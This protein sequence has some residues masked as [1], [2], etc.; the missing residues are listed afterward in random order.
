MPFFSFLKDNSD[1]TD[2]TWR[3]RKRFGPFDKASQHLMRGKSELT[4][5]ERE[6]I[7]AYVSSLNS[8]QYCFGSHKS[9]A[10]AF[11]I[12]ESLLTNITSDLESAGLSQKQKPIFS[13]VKLLTLTPHKVIQKDAQAVFDAGWS[14]RTLQ[15]VICI[16]GL[17]CFYNRLLDGHGVKGSSTMYDFA[18]T[19]LSK[20]GY[21]VPWFINLVK[22][23]IKKPY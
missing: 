5:A 12:S 7:A 21:S 23:L 9:V 14:E 20:K 13:Y 2:I 8:C 19:F 22:Y 11:G 6:L 3:D 15:D 18:G 17:F 10:K 16:V 1:I 4:F